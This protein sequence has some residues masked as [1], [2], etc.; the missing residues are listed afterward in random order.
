MR[1]KK[2]YV[3]HDYIVDKYNCYI[4]D[5]GLEKILINC[6]ENSFFHLYKV[7]D[8]VLKSKNT[9]EF[10]SNVNEL[11]NY[12]YKND[13]EKK[14]LDKAIFC[15]VLNNK[16]NN[17]DLKKILLNLDYKFDLNSVTYY[18]DEII[19]SENIRKLPYRSSIRMRK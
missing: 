10:S 13:V 1:S 4:Y 14:L 6:E 16:N 9:T 11:I 18:S 3:K 2:I 12:N 7:I 15:I 8:N 17:F 5:K 19:L